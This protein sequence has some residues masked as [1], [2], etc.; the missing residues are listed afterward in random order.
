MRR[1]T[2]HLRRDSPQPWEDYT[3]GCVLLAQPFFW[4]REH[5]L[6]QP[7]SW[8]RNTQRGARYDLSS[9]D[10]RELWRRVFE[11]LPASVGMELPG[12]YTDP[13]PTRHRVGTGIFRSVVTDVYERRCA[14]TRERALPALDA[15]HIRPFSV[16]P[17]NYVQNG[18]LLRSDVHRLFDAGYVTVTPDYRV[19]VSERMQS[20]FDDGENYLKFRGTKL[21]V[22]RALEDRPGRGYLEWHNENRFRR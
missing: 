5:W 8:A 12:G 1:R 18:M 15:A 10:G 2:A 7:A 16:V 11:R 14:V 17:A 20:D 13:V 22:P 3:I 4:E 19:E 9:R 6:P 21:W